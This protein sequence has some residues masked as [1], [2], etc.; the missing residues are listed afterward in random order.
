[1]VVSFIGGG[2]WS[3]RR[4]PPTCCKSLTNFRFPFG[5]NLDVK[6]LS[7][8]M[9]IINHS[10]ILQNR[11]ERTPNR[12]LFFSLTVYILFLPKGPR[13]PDNIVNINILAKRVNEEVSQ[14][15]RISTSTWLE[16]IVLITSFKINEMI[17]I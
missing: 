2:Y 5:S 7:L 8:N 17:Y 6:L 13:S 15:F 4:K 14:R 10:V 11:T 12:I 1:M 16:C 9:S 3:T